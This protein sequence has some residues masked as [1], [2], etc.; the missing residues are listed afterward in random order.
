[1]FN[2]CRSDNTQ[3]TKSGLTPRVFG[4]NIIQQSVGCKLPNVFRWIVLVE[5]LKLRLALVELLVV[6]LQDIPVNPMSLI[7]YLHVKFYLTNKPFP[8]RCARDTRT[9]PQ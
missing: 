2:T 3:M 9:P 7:T 6:A 8:E 5:G 1:M 4:E